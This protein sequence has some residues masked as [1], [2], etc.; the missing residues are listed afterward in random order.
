[1]KSRTAERF[2]KCYSNLP[3][4]IKRK[5]R[6]AY[7]R[8]QENSYH[9]SL[10]FKRVHSTRPIFSIRITRNHRAVGVLQGD[11]MVW[12]WIGGHS[13]Y[14]KLLKQMRNA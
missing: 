11:E 2:W 5:A 14:D 9:P 1:M 10:H 4:S 6:E 3:V 7:L 8:F 12:F 13:E